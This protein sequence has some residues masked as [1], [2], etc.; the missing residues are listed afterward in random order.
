MNPF[1]PFRGDKE[2]IGCRRDG[3]RAPLHSAYGSS[4]V[5]VTV[6][7]KQTERVGMIS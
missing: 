6:A 2:L 5:A 7:L 3:I 4:R 1:C